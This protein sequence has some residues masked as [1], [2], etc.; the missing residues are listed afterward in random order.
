MFGKGRFSQR[1]EVRQIFRIR[2]ANLQ[3]IKPLRRTDF[4]ERR[5]RKIEE[6]IEKRVH[7]QESIP[8]Q[9][10]NRRK[11]KGLNFAR[12]K[13]DVTTGR[14]EEHTS[15]L[16]SLTNLVCRLLLEKKKKKDKKI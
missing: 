7:E 1:K 14:S 13:M 16:Q 2:Q 3:S 4:V 10:M 15:E 11:L 12:Q 5:A 8:L 6:K 9:R